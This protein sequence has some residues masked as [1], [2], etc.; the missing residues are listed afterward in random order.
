VE[1]KTNKKQTKKQRREENRKHIAG[2]RKALADEGVC[3]TVFYFLP[4]EMERAKLFLP[5]IMTEPFSPS[6]KLQ[7]LKWRKGAPP[8]VTTSHQQSGQLYLVM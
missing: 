8:A 4:E 1:S 2:L 6:R 7:Q 5:K 3:S